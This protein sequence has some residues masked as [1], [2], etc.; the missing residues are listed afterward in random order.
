MSDWIPIEFLK[1]K[2]HLIE[3]ASILNM[4]LLKMLSFGYRDNKIETTATT[5]TDIRLINNILFGEAFLLK[6][7]L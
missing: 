4:S 3:W 2:N 1:N 6:K 5:S 7:F